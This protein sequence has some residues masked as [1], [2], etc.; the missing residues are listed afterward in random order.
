M[1]RLGSCSEC[2]ASSPVPRSLGPAL[3]WG[4]GPTLLLQ[5][6]ARVM[7]SEGFNMALEFHHVWLLWPSV[8]TWVPDINTD[9]NYSRTTDPDMALSS[10]LSQ[11]FTMV[12]MVRSHKSVW[13]QQQHGSRTPTCTQVVCLWWSHRMHGVIY[14]VVNLLRLVLCFSILS[15]LEKVPY[16]T[17]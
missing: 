14:I 9:P 8:V 11:D 16:G 3:S 13:P 1:G 7:A 5:C 10:N 15:V 4:E 17:E 2:G 12:P 6:P